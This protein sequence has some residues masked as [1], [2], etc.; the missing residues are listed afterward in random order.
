MDIL[1]SLLFCTEAVGV[2]AF[3]IS[4][5]GVA[6][7]KDLDLFGIIVLGVTTATG[8]GV[9]RDLLLGVTPPGHVSRPRLCGDGLCNGADDVFSRP[10]RHAGAQAPLGGVSCRR[11]AVRR[12][13]PWGFR[14]HRRLCGAG[15]GLSGK[16]VFGRLCGRCDRNRRRYFARHHGRGD[17]LCAQQ[18][19]LCAGRHHGG[20]VL[21]LDGAQGNFG[22]HVLGHFADRADSRACRALRLAASQG[23]PREKKQE[24]RT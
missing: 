23:P 14:G 2:V 20:A 16:W 1:S 5:A 19:H 4:G 6:I 24:E 22:S 17:S 7:E 21:L 8:G 12:R 9:I 10:L 18:A 11:G 13:R 15:G 3:A